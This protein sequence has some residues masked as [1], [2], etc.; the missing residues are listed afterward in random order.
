MCGLLLDD[1]QM[2]DETPQCPCGRFL[3][4]DYIMGEDGKEYCSVACSHR[5]GPALVID[6]KELRTR[7]TNNRNAMALGAVLNIPIT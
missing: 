2:I 7:R 3:V 1:E 5:Y 4:F 6:I